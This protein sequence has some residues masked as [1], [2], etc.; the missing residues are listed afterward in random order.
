VRPYYD[1]EQPQ[2]RMRF[3]LTWTNTVKVLLVVN[4][5]AYLLGDIIDRSAGYG[6][7][8]ATFGYSLRGLL[9]GR[10]WQPVT[11]MFV[12][13]GPWHLLGNMLG[14]FFFG[15]DVERR[16]GPRRFLAFYLACGLGGAVLGSFYAGG[17]IGA[18]G[19]VYGV[20][21]AFAIFYP[22]AK[23]YAWPLIF[24]PIKARYMALVWVFISVAGSLGGGGGI[25]HLAHLG[26]IVVA[27]AWI[28]GGPVWARRGAG[29]QEAGRERQ[30]KRS[31]DEQAEMDRILAK[32]HEEGIHS[33]SG[34]EKR[35]LNR[36]SKRYGG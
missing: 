1:Y 24:F 31:A 32:V 33:L 2:Y 18:S 23:I 9:Y 28:W 17:V 26:G 5:A 13:E 36:M 3:G 14:L 25:A 16:F 21:I 15:G 29:F 12:H 11:Y 4:A 8:E 19:A 35:F 20:L 34:S 7:F 22:D 27:A 10:I 30:R 6:L